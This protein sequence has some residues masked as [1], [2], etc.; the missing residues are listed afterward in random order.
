MFLRRQDVNLLITIT[1]KPTN[2]QDPKG[3]A[4][5]KNAETPTESSKPK[6]NSASFCNSRPCLYHDQRHFKKSDHRVSC[7]SFL[8]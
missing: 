4:I 5:Q 8:V 3:P 7:P 2:N 6:V 1:Y